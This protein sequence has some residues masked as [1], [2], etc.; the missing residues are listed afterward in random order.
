MLAGSG[1]VVANASGIG[2]HDKPVPYCGHGGAGGV[3]LPAARFC[4]AFSFRLGITIG[5]AEAADAASNEPASTRVADAASRRVFLNKGPSRADDAG[6][7][8]SGVRNTTGPSVDAESPYFRANGA[9][10]VELSRLNGP[11]RDRSI[12]E[13]L[14]RGT[15]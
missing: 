12:R 3:I 1:S 5:F 14:S 15:E 6:S 10:P 11:F 9:G 7:S 4:W 8:V 13:F 2:V